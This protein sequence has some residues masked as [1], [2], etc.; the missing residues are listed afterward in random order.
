MA[1]NATMIG[2]LSSTARS[3]TSTLG[4]PPELID[5]AR[6]RLM[7]IASLFAVF[8]GLGMLTTLVVS[9]FD[10]MDHRFARLR[11]SV[12]IVSLFISGLVIWIC[13]TPRFTNR[14]ALQVGCF[15]EVYVC[16]TI[17][18]SSIWYASTMLGHVSFISWTTPVIIVFGALVPATPRRTLYTGLAA[19][20]T[21][22][23]A[24]GVLQFCGEV[25]FRAKDFAMVTVSP[26]AAV[27]VAWVI[28]RTLYRLGADLREAR[29]MGSYKLEALLG[30]GGMGEVWKANHQLLARPA[31][32][33]L[34]RNKETTLE[35][36]ALARRRFER[37]AQATAA[38]HSPHTV[39]LY[40]FGVTGEG[41]FYYVMEL[42][43]GLDLKTL[44]DEH[45]PLQAER[46]VHVLLQTCDSL[47]DAHHTGLV[48][49]DV[50]PANI[51]LCKKGLHHD[52]VK[53]VDFGLVALRRDAPEDAQLT[54][55][56]VAGGTPAFMSPE[57]ATGEGVVDGRSDIYSLG[58]VAYWLLSG[59]LVFPRD[60]VM[61]V[62][63]AHARDEPEP[64]ADVT[65]ME[66]P[67]ALEQL[68]MDCLAK[69]PEDRPQSALELAARLKALELTGVW[70]AE[71]A[72]K[73]WETRKPV[74]TVA[75]AATRPPPPAKT[76]H[77]CLF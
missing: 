60:S 23:F 54:A 9:S 30:E 37:E 6:R 75:A 40:D 49:R 63:V 42:L 13:R 28:A 5:Q 59:R 44:V 4:L 7:M 16:L 66:V 46:V 43:E 8:F 33:K 32:I 29:R 15:Y 74:T 56:G 71:H 65:E 72:Q 1:G 3:S 34:I 64:F 53:V 24:L 12:H 31:A 67:P 21:E 73:W 76:G 25:P 50:K 2:P 52:F 17:A 36:Q 68:V 55:D 47:A 69:D 41:T 11:G 10:L 57:Q 62:I 45:G 48:H 22:P 14:V 19:A 61:S 27:F 20:M 18:L 58:C 35:H 77:R 38:L 39:Q 70:E 26:L 51:L